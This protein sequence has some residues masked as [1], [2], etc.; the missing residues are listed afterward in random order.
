MK[1]FVIFL[2]ILFIIT[3]CSSDTT[4][5]EEKSD[6]LAWKSELVEQ[7]NFSSNEELNCDI[8]VSVDRVSDDVVSYT[9]FLSNPKEDMHS[10]KMMVVH[11]YFT[12]EVF[13]T[14]GIFDDT[15]EL[16]EDD[17][18]NITLVGYIDTTQDIQ[19]LNLELRIWIE[20]T[21]NDGN[22][23]DIYYKTTK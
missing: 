12:E 13:P 10:I 16:L 17:D 23:K 21:D 14:I 11:N 20:Y 22:I 19:K 9:T 1:R 4:D 18:N 3:G 5:Q 8:T 7:D 15:K 2:F 6:Y